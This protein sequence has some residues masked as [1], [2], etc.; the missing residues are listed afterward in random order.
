[1]LA[2][3]R[4]LCAALLLAVT[5]C[6]DTNLSSPG[7]RA[8][9]DNNNP[10]RDIAVSDT[11][12]ARLRNGSLQEIADGKPLFNAG[13]KKGKLNGAWQSWYTNGAVCDSG[14]MINNIPHGTW[15]YWDNKGNLLA[16]RE[17]N[18]DKY[19]RIKEEMMRYNSRRS[20]Y[21]LAYMY[22]QKKTTALKYVTANYSFPGGKKADRA[23]TGLKEVVQYNITDGNTYI[24][25]FDNCLHEGQYTNYFSNG[26]IKDSGY[27]KDG[28]KTGIWVHYETAGGIHYEGRYENGIRIKDWRVYHANHRIR[29]VIHYDNKGKEQWRKTIGR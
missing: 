21:Y 17:Y 28:L 3:Q 29:D 5:G 13:I 12:L 15:K 24:P 4:L 16:V 8:L 2:C 25:V 23:G 26:A 18:A 27:Y 1:M 19:R 6:A 7:N 20:F 9:R 14:Y 10:E 22:Q 11:S